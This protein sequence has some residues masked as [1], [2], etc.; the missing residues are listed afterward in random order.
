MIAGAAKPGHWITD[1]L[2]AVIANRVCPF[3]NFRF[4]RGLNFC[5]LE[6]QLLVLVK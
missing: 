4:Q 3:V 6:S 5:Q 2:L 1:S